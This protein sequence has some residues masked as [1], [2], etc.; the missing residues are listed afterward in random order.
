MPE[1]VLTDNGKQF[2]A[3]F[4]H[5]GEVLFDRIC[6]DNAITHRSPRRLAD[7]HREDRAV[8]VRHEA[9]LLYPPRS[10]EGL[11]G[12]SLGLMADPEPKGDRGK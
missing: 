11:R 10:G 9:Q 2:T 12:G 5:G 3:R 7:H 1:E 8:P 4:G 6:R